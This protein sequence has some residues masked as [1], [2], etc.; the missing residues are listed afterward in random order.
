MAETEAVRRS[1]RA[2]KSGMRVTHSLA[3]ISEFLA[4][5]TFAHDGNLLPPGTPAVRDFKTQAYDSYIQ[6]TWK[7]LPS[8]TLTLGLRYSLERPVYEAQ[9]FET[10][11]TSPLGKLFDARVAAGKQGL[12]NTDLI[13]VD[14]SGP[15]N[16]GKSLYNWDK[17][18]FQP[19][20]AFAWSLDPQSKSVLRGGF[21]LTNDYFG[22]ALAVDFDLGNA[23][24][25][26]QR[27]DTHANT[28]NVSTRLG[29][30]FATFNDNVRDLIGPQN[31]PP[32]P[33]QFPATPTP[34]D[35]IDNFGL[36]IQRSLDSNLHAPNEY[37]WNLTFE[38]QLP[39]GAVLSLSYI[40]RKARSLLLRRDVAA[41]N[42]LRD[43]Q[44]GVD[45][46]TAG[47]EL[48]KLRSQ[49]VPISQVPALLPAQVSQYFANM[50]PA[51]LA[52]LLNDYEGLPNDPAQNQGGFDNNWS[53]AQAFLGYSSSNIG[54]FTA[55]D[56]TDTQAEIDLALAANQLPLRF[57]QPQYG[58]LSTWAT[59]GN[60]NYHALTVSLRQRLSALTFDF[61]YTW[62]HS[63]DDASGLQSETG[64]G[65]QQSNGAFV[66]NPLR[67]HD[68]YASSDFDIRHN[69]NADV[70]W[71]L[72]FGKG[73]PLLNGTN[74]FANAL[75]GGWQLSGIFRWNTGLPVFSPF[76]DGTW[77]TN[78]DISSGVT[79]LHPLTT[80]PSKPKD[81][82]APKLFGNCKGGVNAVYQ[83][84]RSS[85]PG[86]VGPR[87]YLRY[88]GYIDV[89]LGFGK[90]W[91]MPWNEGHQLQLRWDVF[92]VTNT[93]RLIG[94]TDAAVAPDPAGQS[95]PADWSNFTGIQGTPRVMQIGARY[96]F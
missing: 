29:P 23:V 48:E 82:S 1:F 28:F 37:V 90:T 25:Y 57:V 86:E 68:N 39:K 8:L 92:N 83:S 22:Q 35:G 41:F 72:P 12:N 56:W 4:F 88:P 19:R 58:A 38:R 59:A 78:W 61:N 64:F 53:N 43:P 94:N 54:F 62:S 17:N 85:Y 15:V 18:N 5:F 40:G 69:I 65:N 73:Q 46:Y 51:G 47:R 60:S 20:V 93:Q 32:N 24:G 6:D 81:L 14:K 71:Q 9:G 70:V 67:Q 42:D 3:V 7:V 16:G 55:N 66:V 50:W 45:W 2:A 26:T 95:A 21:A 11:P 76:D 77:S 27:F 34:L 79:P 10:Q 74:R 91:R 33:I 96:T 87:N 89:D 84:F 75:F 13:T 80:C 30:Q 49:G 63:L 31:I 44:T 36:L 52:S